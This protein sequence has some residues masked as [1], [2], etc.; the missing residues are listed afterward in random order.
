MKM[1]FLE[2]PFPPSINTYWGF[3]GN[4][5]FLTKKAL[6]FKAEVKSIILAT[7]T[8]SFN[9]DLLVMNIIWFPP[10]KRIRDIDNPIKPL[11]DALVQANVMNDDSQIKKL[12]LEFADIFKGGKALVTITNLKP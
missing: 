11:L 2:L 7:N 10:D 12:T 4:K 8:K 5:R 6:Q 9:D 3:H 1:I